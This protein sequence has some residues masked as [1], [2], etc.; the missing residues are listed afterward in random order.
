MNKLLKLALLSTALCLSAC[1]S[2]ER[3]HQDLT[4]KMEDVPT[5]VIIGFSKTHP[6]A[7]IKAVERQVHFD[8]SVTYGFD[9]IENKKPAN[10]VMTDKGEPAKM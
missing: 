10:Y 8:G 5:K 7:A 6:N 3:Y 9:V 4:D 2:R 1:G